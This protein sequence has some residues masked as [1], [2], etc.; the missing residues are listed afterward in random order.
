MSNSSIP[1]D[2]G[3]VGFLMT[4]DYLFLASS[5]QITAKWREPLAVAVVTLLAGIFSLAHGQ[6]IA[7]RRRDPS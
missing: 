1:L 6:R 5:Q 3:V 2:H 7:F 4:V